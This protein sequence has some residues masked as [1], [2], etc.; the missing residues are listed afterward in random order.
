MTVVRDRGSCFC[1]CYCCC[2]CSCFC[3]RSPPLSTCCTVLYCT[4]LRPIV[5]YSDLS[6]FCN[7]FFC[8]V[9][10]AHQRLPVDLFFVGWW[11][12]WYEGT[13]NSNG[14]CSTLRTSFK[15]PDSRGLESLSLRVRHQ[16]LGSSCSPPPCHPS[17]PSLQPCLF[18]LSHQRRTVPFSFPS[19]F[20]LLLSRSNG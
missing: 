9:V 3:F 11:L 19:S 10:V 15:S 16:D 6:S 2:S 8:C 12:A 5:F 13:A 20:S 14:L 4:V 7:N 17:S 18:S 1:Y